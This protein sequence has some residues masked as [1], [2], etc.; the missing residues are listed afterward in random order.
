MTLK[1]RGGGVGWHRFFLLKSF[2]TSQ[3]SLVDDVTENITEHVSLQNFRILVQYLSEFG[4]AHCA[5]KIPFR[6]LLQKKPRSLYR[7]AIQLTVMKLQK[8]IHHL[9]RFIDN[10]NQVSRNDQRLANLV[11]PLKPTRFFAVVFGKNSS[12]CNF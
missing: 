5:T 9:H 4:C 6:S 10:L 7:T 1:L 11:K 12:L 8:F 3:A 2:A